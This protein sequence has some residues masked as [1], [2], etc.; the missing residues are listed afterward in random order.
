MNL[1]LLITSPAD[2]LT[3]K[4]KK[5]ENQKN[6]NKKKNKQVDR[7]KRQTNRARNQPWFVDSTT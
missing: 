5:S 1:A 7:L 6:K 3:K 2:Q 4:H